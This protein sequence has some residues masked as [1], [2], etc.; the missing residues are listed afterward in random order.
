MSI[1]CKENEMNIKTLLGFIFLSSQIELVLNDQSIE[2]VTQVE[3][4]H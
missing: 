3:V 4:Q 1:G 2:F